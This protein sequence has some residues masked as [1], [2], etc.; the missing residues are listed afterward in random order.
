MTKAGPRGPLK[1]ARLG[2]VQKKVLV[3]LLGIQ[4]QRRRLGESFDGMPYKEIHARLYNQAF[5]GESQWLQTVHAQMLLR[6]GNAQEANQYLLKGIDLAGAAVAG[7]L[8]NTLRPENALD[9]ETR[10][11]LA[12]IQDEVTRIQNTASF[13]QRTPMEAEQDALYT[14]LLSLTREV[15]AFVSPQL[16]ASQGEARFSTLGDVEKASALKAVNVQQASLSRALRGLLEHGL[17]LQERTP[18]NHVDDHERRYFITHAGGERLQQEVQK[19]G[20]RR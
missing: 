9:I 13:L 4:M 11:L 15:A 5:I 6:Q 7:D 18:I 17:I 19:I 1:Q 16:L 12:S 3:V 14:T 8:R 20:S 2:V 10:L